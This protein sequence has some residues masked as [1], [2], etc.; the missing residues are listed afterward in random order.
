MSSPLQQI[1]SLSPLEQRKVASLIGALVADA[2]TRPT[3]WEYDVKVLKAKIQAQKPEFLTASVSPFY[4][5][6]TGKQSGYGDIC[7]GNLSL[8]KTLQLSTH[9]YIP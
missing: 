4:D 8:K 1:V 7:L 5:L 2:A 3:H 6:P 9:P